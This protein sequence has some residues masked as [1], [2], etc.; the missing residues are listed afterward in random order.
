MTRYVQVGSVVTNLKARPKTLLRHHSLLFTALI[1]YRWHGSL[2][3]K[4]GTL[5]Q[6]WQSSQ[7]FYVRALESSLEARRVVGISESWKRKRS[8]VYIAK[9]HWCHWCDKYVS[10]KTKKAGDLRSWKFQW[11]CSEEASCFVERVQDMEAMAHTRNRER[12]QECV[13]WIS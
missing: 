7:K 8:G 10:L 6:Q 11:E 9:P 13:H 4:N 2:Q 12:C 5:I 1:Y 3:C